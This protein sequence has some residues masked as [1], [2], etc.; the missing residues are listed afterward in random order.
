MTRWS[1]DDGRR[2][3]ARVASYVV[4]HCLGPDPR[5][6]PLGGRVARGGRV[7]RRPPVRLWRGRE[8]PFGAS[9][10]LSGGRGGGVPPRGP[11]FPLLGPPP[12]PPPPPPRAANFWLRKIPGAA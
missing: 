9:S 10:G 5:R 6:G 2:H 1:E 12:P 8:N 4:P 7:R 11:P 3:P